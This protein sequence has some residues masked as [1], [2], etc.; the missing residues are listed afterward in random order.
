M[1]DGGYTWNLKPLTYFMQ[2]KTVTNLVSNSQ[3]GVEASD[4][5]TKRAPVPG[6]MR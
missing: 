3:E 2:I 1:V 6:A 5:Q 4:I